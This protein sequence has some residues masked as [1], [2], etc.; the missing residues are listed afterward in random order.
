MSVKVEIV[1]PNVRKVNVPVEVREVVFERP[2]FDLTLR[3]IGSAIGI[4][5]A[6]IALVE[7]LLILAFELVVEC[8]VVDA[9]AAFKKPIDLVQVRLE[10]L[11]VVLQLPRFHQ[12]RVELLMPLV[13]ARIVLP[14]IVI[15]L[16]SVCLQQALSAVGQ[17]HRDVPLTRHPSGVDEAQFAEVS[18]FA[19]ALVQRPIVAVAKVLG[20]HDSEGADG[21][22]RAALRAPQ[23]VLAL[24]IEHS[25]ALGSAGQVELA[26]EH[27][28]R[29]RTVALTHVAVTRILVTLSGIVCGSRIAGH[30]APPSERQR[31]HVHAA[32]Q[33]SCRYNLLR[34]PATISTCSERSPVSGDLFVFVAALNIAARFPFSSILSSLSVGVRIMASTSPRSASVA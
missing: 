22:Q 7:P 31:F 14:R 28:S 26:Q 11:R 15:A 34:A 2:S 27:V 25:L 5:V 24:A 19:V 33:Q 8:D 32:A 1:D 23:R 12:P 4:R 16:V 13:L 17:K 3:P 20:W 10:H 6:S 9:I 21:G 29:V 30:R 18:Q